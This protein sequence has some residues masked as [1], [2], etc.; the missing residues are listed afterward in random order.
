[1][2]ADTALPVPLLEDALAISRE[3]GIRYVGA[4]ILGTL[5]LATDDPETRQRALSEGEKILREGCLSHNYFEFYTDALETC[6]NVGD[7]NGAERYASALEYYTRNVPLPLTDF[8]ISRGR[9]LAAFA[10]GERD[11]ATVQ[12][13]RHLCDE[14]EGWVSSALPALEEALASVDGT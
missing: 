1:M 4:V 7:W 2:E 14:A 9:A 5:A 6:L 12:D 11:D 3:T 13:L 8:L 10:R